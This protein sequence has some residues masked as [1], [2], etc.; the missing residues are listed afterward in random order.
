LSTKS[1]FKCICPN[2]H[3]ETYGLVQ[4]ALLERSVTNAELIPEEYLVCCG[5]LAI[6]S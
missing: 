1:Q 6:Y 5:S 4:Q 3:R 2:A